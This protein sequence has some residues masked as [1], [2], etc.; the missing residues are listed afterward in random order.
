MENTPVS[1]NGA[2]PVDQTV[3]ASLGTALINHVRAI[4]AAD[5][6]YEREVAR[7]RAEAV[8]KGLRLV[9]GGQDAPRHWSVEDAQTHEVLATGSTIDEYDAA[10]QDDWQNV[11]HLSDFADDIWESPP[12]PE[13]L[14]GLWRDAIESEDARAWLRRMESQ[15]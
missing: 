4:V 11:D 8:A 3:A 2:Q 13:A 10:W 14:A 5:D 6:E 1:T 7:R 9:S 12:V 15:S